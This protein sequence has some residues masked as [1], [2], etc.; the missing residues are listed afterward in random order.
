MSGDWTR[1]L[2]APDFLG[3]LYGDVPPAPDRCDL[4]YVHID[5]RE[6]SVT[7]GFD[8]RHL[9]EDSPE[10]WAGKDFNVFAFSIVFTG[11]DDLRVTGWGAAEAR[12]VDV[13]VQP[14]GV[15]DVVLGSEGSGITFRA[16][17]ARLA[18]TRAYLASGSP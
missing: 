13:S 12:Q 15:F 8:T 14:G 4:A 16:P 5:E 17:A 3:E 10:E 1:I 2:S 18:G 6:N 11:V 9:P 7:L